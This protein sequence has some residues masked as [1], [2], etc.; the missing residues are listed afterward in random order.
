MVEYRGISLQELMNKFL[1]IVNYDENDFKTKNPASENEQIKLGIYKMISSMGNTNVSSLN[2]CFFNAKYY[3]TY[4]FK[5]KYYG[6]TDYF[7][8]Y[9]YNQYLKDQSK[10]LSKLHYKSFD[11]YLLQKL[12]ATIKN[13]ISQ[14][15][16]EDEINLDED[17]IDSMKKTLK[18]QILLFSQ[19]QFN[20]MI[21]YL[22][23][24]KEKICESHFLHKSNIDGFLKNLFTLVLRT[25]RIEDED[26]YL[27]LKNCFE[28]FDES[29]FKEDKENKENV[30]EG[31]ENEEYEEYE[32]NK[33]ENK[34]K[35]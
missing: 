19:K 30:D 34:C 10:F 31:E 15:F 24:G 5:L 25:K 26:I 9:E 2:I 17:I 35:K 16:V 11:K 28:I 29:I 14:K 27:N 32:D 6:L 7:V 13:D 1:F 21:K 18:T 23:F 20:L 12:K 4:I 33:T 22:A 8:N 3:E